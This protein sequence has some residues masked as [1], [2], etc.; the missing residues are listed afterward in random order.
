MFADALGP[1]MANA[2]AGAGRGWG[3]RA[4][5]KSLP[6]AA[7]VARGDLPQSCP[8]QGA[9]APAGPGACLSP[10]GLPRAAALGGCP[11]PREGQ[12]GG[13]QQGVNGQR[14]GCRQKA[15]GEEKPPLGKLSKAQ[16]AGLRHRELC[17]PAAAAL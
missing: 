2:G 1:R 7:P 9:G 4:P 6:G 5:P 11:S 10:A 15:A 8:P 16:L 3:A 12:V 14:G 17:L 13:G